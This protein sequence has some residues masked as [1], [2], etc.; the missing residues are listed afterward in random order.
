MEQD[1]L[2]LNSD[3][4]EFDFQQLENRLETD[5]LMMDGMIDLS[6]SEF[7]TPC[8]DFSCPYLFYCKSLEC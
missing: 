8:S 6:L 2:P 3:Y 7:E 5:P 4:S 1:F